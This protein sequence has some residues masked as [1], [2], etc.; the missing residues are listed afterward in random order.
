MR[1]CVD[2]NVFYNILFRTEKRGKARRLLEDHASW[3]LYI[4]TTVYNELVYTVTVK[5]LA[6]PGPKTL[7]R[8]VA[9]KGYPPGSGESR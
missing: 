2:T 5:L 8:L 6:R 7:R 9:S 4:T 1:A 3:D